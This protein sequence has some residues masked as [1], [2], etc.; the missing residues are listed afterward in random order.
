MTSRTVSTGRD[1]FVAAP[2]SMRRDTQP[3]PHR[4]RRL[5][6]SDAQPPDR[7]SSAAVRRL[8][9]EDAAALGPLARFAGDPAV[10]DIFV[11]G[12]GAAFLDRGH[13]LRPIE[14]W[15]RPEEAQLRALAVR[16]IARGGR[17]I[18]EAQPCV[19][20][21]LGD[22]VRVH[23][24]L[25]PVS[26]RGTLL[27]IRLPRTE[28]PDLRL[29]H[30]SGAFP[31]GVEALLREAV[32]GRRNL[33][34]TGAAGSGKTTLMAA[35]LGLAAPHER[36][37][38]IED[39]AE[40]RIRHP[41]VVGLEARQANIEGAGA[42]DLQ[43]LLREALRMRP[44][45]LVLGECRGAEIRELLTALNTG[46]DG[47]AGTLH[48]N[49]VADVPSRLEALGALAGLNPQAVARQAAAAIDLVVHVERHGSRRSVSALGTFMVDGRGN[50]RISEVHAEELALD[51]A[52]P[53]D[54]A[55]DA[56]SGRSQAGLP[57]DGN[58][59]DH[60]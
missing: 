8:A 47:G 29:L 16:I 9:P 6:S 31:P 57:P 45:R 50:L 17:H 34:I 4:H 43:R 1:P 58:A 12:D 36:I 28:P 56:A 14:V 55:D 33:L 53:D 13:G 19:D 21:R 32:A 59:A 38:T 30:Q 5:E 20:V 60:A 26:P 54:R 42:I 35:L 7:R 37:V 41:H 39:V 3:Q 24:V 10:T 25:P 2:P 11:N 44:D 48:A 46:H 23:A 18:D 15:R 49:S 22:G 51:E 52:E 27:S 40:L